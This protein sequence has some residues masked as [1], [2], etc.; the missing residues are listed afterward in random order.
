[1][2]LTDYIGSWDELTRQLDSGA[3]LA[4][5]Q[6]AE[7]E[8]ARF[9]SVSDI[10]GQVRS[11]DV[12][13]ALVRLA[14]AGDDD[15][16]LVVLHLLI[17]AASL[18]CSRLRNLSPD[19]EALVVGELAIQVRAFP[20]ERRTRAFAANVLQDAN[21]A[22]LREL[23]YAKRR[24]TATVCVWAGEDFETAAFSSQVH[25]ESAAGELVDVL[26]WAERSG[27]VDA[28]EVA[29]LLAMASPEVASPAGARSHAARQL[30]ISVSTVSRRHARAV[31]AIAGSLSAY[32]SV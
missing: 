5:W 8:L 4:A 32:L 28:D 31:A 25:E 17:P 20:V 6:L 12:L 29:V 22:L 26:M 27:I 30:G 15:A 24:Q 23:T 7:P 14:A 2:A 3:V 16:L 21:A 13:G 19:I 11:D 18:M 10:G 1:M 9:A